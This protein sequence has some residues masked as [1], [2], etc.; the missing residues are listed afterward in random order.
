MVSST[1]THTNDTGLNAN[2]TGRTPGDPSHGVRASVRVCLDSIHT[3]HR[4]R[5]E[6]EKEEESRGQIQVGY[7]S[8]Q[9]KP[10]EGGGVLIISMIIWE[11]KGVRMQ[12]EKSAK[13][14]QS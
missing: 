5:E 9:R 8:R 1:T 11:L 3:L 13:K 14:R 2:A 12:S 6:G 4:I 10:L 7:L